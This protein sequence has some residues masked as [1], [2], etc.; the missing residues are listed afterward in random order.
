MT[1]GSTDPRYG[2]TKETQ[3]IDTV[4]STITVER[5]IVDGQTIKPIRKHYEYRERVKDKKEEM[6]EYLR[7]SSSLDD[8][9]LDPIFKL[10]HTKHGK[11]NGYYYV[12]KCWTVTEY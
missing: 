8:T 3:T 6:T 4:G 10:E 2:S 12:V 11:E 7:F 1:T 5:N 9:K